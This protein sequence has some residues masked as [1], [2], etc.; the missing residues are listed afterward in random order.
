MDRRIPTQLGKEG[1]ILD[2]ATPNWKLTTQD[3]KRLPC[4]EAIRS[5]APGCGSFST[6]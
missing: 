2:S 5:I 6:K 3:P 1:Q 4:L